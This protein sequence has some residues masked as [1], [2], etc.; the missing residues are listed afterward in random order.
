MPA[1]AVRPI[2]NHER[3]GKITRLL[4]FYDLT[5]PPTSGKLGLL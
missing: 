4:P 3:A 2:Q 1:L 5:K